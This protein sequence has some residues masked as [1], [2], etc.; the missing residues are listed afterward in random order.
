M[1]EEKQNQ[2]QQKVDQATWVS[3]L[4]PKQLAKNGKPCWG[5]VFGELFLKNEI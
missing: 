5:K 3:H 2:S 4:T 1:A